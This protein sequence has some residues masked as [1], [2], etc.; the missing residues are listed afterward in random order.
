MA[1]KPAP[2]QQRVPLTLTTELYDA[3]E[4]KGRL[5]HHSAEEEM[6]TR[7]TTCRDHT[8]PTALYIDDTTRQA[9]EAV[10]G[11]Q[12]K[13]ARDLV[14]WVRSLATLSVAGASVPFGEQLMK[15]IDGRRFGQPLP[16]FVSRTTVDLWE[17]FVGM[18]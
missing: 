5:H 1:T 4:A 15:R 13:S 17:Q 10:A 9:L 11:R 14:A 8:S 18:R 12:L 6:L 16:E 7:L 2:T 3:Y